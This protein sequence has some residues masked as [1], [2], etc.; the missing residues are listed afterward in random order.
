[1]KVARQFTAWNMLE[2]N[3]P[4]H[5]DGVIL[6]TPVCC[7]RPKDAVGPTKSY[8]P[9]GTGH[10][11]YASQAVNCLATFTSPSGRHRFAARFAA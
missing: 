6:T 5:R 8:R 4:S 7:F 1:M 2:K 9:P 10:V 11:F 3:V